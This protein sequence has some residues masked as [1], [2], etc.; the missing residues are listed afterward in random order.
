MEFARK[1]MV[2]LQLIRLYKNLQLVKQT[3]RFDECM[4]FD[5]LNFNLSE[6]HLI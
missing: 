3:G 6:I 5:E 1:K 2:Y 4:L